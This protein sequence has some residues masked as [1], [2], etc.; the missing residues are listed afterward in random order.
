MERVWHHFKEQVF[1]NFS[2][3]SSNVVNVQKSPHKHKL[4][5]SSVISEGIK[6]SPEAMKCP[7][8]TP[9][10]TSDSRPHDIL[11]VVSRLCTG[12]AAGG[13]AQPATGPPPAHRSG[14]CPKP[15]MSAL[16]SVQTR[17]TWSPHR[18]EAPHVLLCGWWGRTAEAA[19]PALPLLPWPPAPPRLSTEAQTVSATRHS[20]ITV[21]LSLAGATSAPS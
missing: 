7:T 6:G 16:P 12:P 11:S 20:R 10:A 17:P 13:R 3:L 1:L 8:K 5:G 14:T 4:L 19:L 21:S 2:D 15:W 18:L 9:R